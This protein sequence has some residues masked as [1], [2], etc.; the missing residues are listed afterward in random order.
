[1]SVCLPTLTPKITKKYC[2]TQLIFRKSKTFNWLTLLHWQ[3]ANSKDDK[4][5]EILSQVSAEI[6]AIENMLLTVLFS[7][8]SPTFEYL[9]THRFANK[10]S[11]LKTCC[12]VN[13]EGEEQCTTKRSTENWNS[14]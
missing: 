11:Y 1:M 14:C 4:G 13:S 7:G 5:D 6:N 3:H 12:C 9:R 10:D 8:M 2:S